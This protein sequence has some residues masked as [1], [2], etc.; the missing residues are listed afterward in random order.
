MFYHDH[1]PKIK[2]GWSD[3]Y[4]IGN[5]IGRKGENLGR[6]RPEN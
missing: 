4:L 5:F 1:L 3:A 2:M 6:I